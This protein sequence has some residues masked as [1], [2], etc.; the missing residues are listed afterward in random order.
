[1]LVSCTGHIEKSGGRNARIAGSHGPVAKV[2][3]VVH[4]DRITPLD[5]D[6]RH[7]LP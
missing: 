1:M 2:F 3:D 5:P 6:V 7:G 4:L